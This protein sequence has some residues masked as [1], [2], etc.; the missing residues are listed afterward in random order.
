MRTQIHHLLEVW[1][2]K[3]VTIQVL[4]FASSGNTGLNE[5]TIISFREE[6]DR[7][8]IYV[9]SL[10]NDHYMDDA[11]A[12]GRYGV[13]FDHL[14]AQALTPD[15]SAAFIA[16]STTFFE[17]AAKKAPLSAFI[18]YSHEDRKIAHRLAA[19]LTEKGV[20]AWVDEGQLRVG[21]SLM[22]RISEAISEIDFVVALVS[23]H[24]VASRWCQQELS[25]AMSGQL[26]G[27]SVRVLPL[28]LEE[29]EMPTSIRDKVWLQV[30]TRNL[31]S[32]VD[33]LVADI[34][35]HHSQKYGPL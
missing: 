5:F 3:N 30:D 28:R 20:L 34:A 9:E 27:P 17:K 15:D 22:V 33:R 16:D 1:A 10:T 31:G 14:N 8:L 32:T 35:S 6:S 12:V 26:G 13:S 11:D 4:P 24:S 23:K 18:S 21:D 29:V 25:W 7:D 19:M 2:L